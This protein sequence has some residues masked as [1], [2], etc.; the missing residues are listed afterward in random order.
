MMNAA[1]YQS[2]PADLREILDA[3]AGAAAAGRL[4][5][6][7]D[8]AERH[9][10]DYM[11]ANDATITPLPPAELDAIRAKLA[12]QTAGIVEALEQS[13]KAAKAF[14]ADYAN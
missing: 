3:T 14:V 13:G 2:L 7:W 1:R 10:R 5:Q 6:S 8:A 11:L 9:G 4:G 12:P